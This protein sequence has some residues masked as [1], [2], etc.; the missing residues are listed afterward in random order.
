M[1]LVHKPKHDICHLCGVGATYPKHFLMFL[2]I[3]IIINI[4]IIFGLIKHLCKLFPIDLN[5]YMTL[6]RNI[7]QTSTVGIF[8][9]TCV[10]GCN[11]CGGCT[12]VAILFQI[13]NLPKKSQNYSFDKF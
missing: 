13:E 4:I 3:I 6:K 1:E 12:M 5:N 2:I 10:G 8:S 11:P 9:W 7:S